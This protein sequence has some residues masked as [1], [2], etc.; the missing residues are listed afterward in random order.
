LN[1]D[2]LGIVIEVEPF[3]VFVLKIV[4]VIGIKKGRKGGKAERRKERILDGAEQGT[5]RFGERGEDHFYAHETG[6]KV[7]I[8]SSLKVTASRLSSRVEVPAVRPMV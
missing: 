8:S 5:L 4:L 6:V 3:D 2:K 7:A 1:D